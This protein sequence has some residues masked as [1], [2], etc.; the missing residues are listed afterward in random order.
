MI[1]VLIVDDSRDDA[2]LTEFALREAGV[3]IECRSIHRESALAAA[4]DGFVPDLV[5]CDL[6]LPGWSCREA[7]D[8]VRRHAPAACC[9]ILTGAEPPD[10]A[11][12]LPEAHAVVLKD[13]PAHLVEL[14]RRLD[15][16]G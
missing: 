6:N 4:L 8:A 15:R 10:G 3:G 12:A 2:E 16:A 7:L 5:L 14:L 11:D 9:V 13:D 1:R